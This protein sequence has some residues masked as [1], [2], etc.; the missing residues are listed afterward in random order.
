MYFETGNFDGMNY[1]ICYPSDYKEGEKYPV[2]LNLHGAGTREI[3]LEEC[4]EGESFAQISAS[5]SDK[6]IIVSPHCTRDSWY[7]IFETL[8]RFANWLPTAPFTDPDRLYLMGTSM[9]GYA[10]WQLAMSQPQLFAAMI[11]ICGGGMYWNASR[12]VNVPVWAFHGAKDTVVYPEESEKLISKLQK[13]GAEAKL[14]IYPE[15]GHNA[16]SDTF[17]NPEVF[18]WLLAHTNRNTKK[19]EVSCQGA[20]EFG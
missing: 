16:W 19:E 8:I 12:L 11:P 1:L 5:A 17:S 3:T 13:K 6:L 10:A 20:K 9:G 18:T 4:K 7:D 2:L 15:N 14:T